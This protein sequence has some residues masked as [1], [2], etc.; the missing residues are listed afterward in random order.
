MFR[1]VEVSVE[2]V[3]KVSAVGSRKRNST[4]CRYRKMASLT[5]ILPLLKVG[6]GNTTYFSTADFVV[7]ALSKP[8]TYLTLAFKG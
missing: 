5:S 2:L 8:H 1:P 3:Y 4:V 7:H 6:L